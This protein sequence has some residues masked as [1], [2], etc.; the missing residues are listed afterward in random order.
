MEYATTSVFRK[1]FAGWK[2]IQNEGSITH[3]SEVIENQI[4]KCIEGGKIVGPLY[5]FEQKFINKRSSAK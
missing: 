2:G 4:I 5:K 3:S 1:L